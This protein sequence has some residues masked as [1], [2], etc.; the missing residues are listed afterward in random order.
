M[1]DELRGEAS[2]QQSI[3]TQSKVKRVLSDYGLRDLGVELEARW[4]AVNSDRAS[5]RQLAIDLNQELLHTVMHDADL[6]P[7]DGEVKNTYRL[8]TAD[9][10]SPGERTDA[11]RHLEREG[12]DVDQLETDF[13]SRQAI[14]TYLTKVRGVTN[15]SNDADPVENAETYLRHLKQRTAT[16]TDSRLTQLRDAGH[17][18]MGSPRVLVDIQIFC[19]DC[20]QQYSLEN[21]FNARSCAC[22]T[23]DSP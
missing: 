8:L 13:V 6:Q 20:G 11:R 9:D 23:I 14:H 4:T 19:E 12:I 7:L 18:S 3:D 22:E 17:L 15:Q 1:E 10:V 16:I 2:E 5:L 21:L